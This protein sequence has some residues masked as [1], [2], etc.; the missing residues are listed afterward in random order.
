MCGHVGNLISKR[1]VVGVTEGIL[2]SA[3]V[4]TTEER[5]RAHGQRRFC[6]SCRTSLAYTW[7]ELCI[8]SL[9]LDT[10]YTEVDG[11]LLGPFL[12]LS[13]MEKP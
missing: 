12:T 6:P 7:C 3:D 5:P 13:M 9:T 11:L 1:D 2:P 4:Y 8:D 10:T